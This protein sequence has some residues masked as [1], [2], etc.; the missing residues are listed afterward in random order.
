MTERSLSIPYLI[1][2]DQFYDAFNELGPDHL[3][4]SISWPRYFL[5]CHAVEL[6]LKAYLLSRG[7]S[8]KE[9]T[10]R[11]IRHNFNKLLDEA[12]NKGLPLAPETQ[13]RIRNLAETHSEFSHR[14][15]KKEDGTL[16]VPVI[17]QSIRAA[18]ELITA[19]HDE[20][21]G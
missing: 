21:G 14:Y 9:V 10:T 11:D 12:V 18:H 3:H 17:A 7:A 8:W 20:V 4:P 5:L 16:E 13:G 15:P 19:V 6:A 2:A 1:Y